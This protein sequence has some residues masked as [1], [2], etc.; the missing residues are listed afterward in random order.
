MQVAEEEN[1]RYGWVMKREV[2]W[3][4]LQV[5]MQQN[6]FVG[7]K[8]ELKEVEYEMDASYCEPEQ[9][10]FL[11]EDDET[12]KERPTKSLTNSVK[13][14]YLLTEE[15]TVRLNDTKGSYVFQTDDLFVIAGFVANDG[16]A[17]E[18][19]LKF[20]KESLS[21]EERSEI[22]QQKELID[23]FIDGGTQSIEYDLEMKE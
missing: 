1:Q 4:S 14:T 23:E 6:M 13:N 18:T 17:F 21:N 2:R 10:P 7:L 5:K 15:M 11:G 9:G 22:L 19:V 16:H 20:D 8:K 12:E 3:N